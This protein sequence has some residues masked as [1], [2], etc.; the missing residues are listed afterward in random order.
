MSWPF[1]GGGFGKGFG[2][3]EM[4]VVLRLGWFSTGRDEAARQLLQVVT[5][6]IAS[7]FLGAEI[8]YVFCNRTRG[9]SPETD[10]FMDLV[11]KL[12]LPL[13]SLSSKGFL[14]SL[15]E[16]DREA[17][18]VRYHEEVAQRI[19]NLPV[20]LI[21]LA[22]YMLIVSGPFCQGF[23]LINLHPAEPG[24]PKG[25]WQEV[26]WEWIRRRASHGGV[27]IHRVTP[28]LDEGPPITYVT[29]SL[30]RG[31]LEGLWKD[32]ETKVK[33]RRWEEVIREEGEQTPLFQ[34]IRREGVRRELP[35]IVLTIQALSEG[36]V[37][38]AQGK[39]LDSEG[40]EI[41]GLCLNEEVEKWLRREES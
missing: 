23:S 29:F 41:G 22:G 28:D 38:V 7:G 8:V 15:R 34:A 36:R 13:I 6:H 3:G 16:R 9:E 11:E 21:V 40:K 24:G 2:Q 25:T 20:D 30:R 26:I 10:R 39:V 5:D 19:R 32:L 31:G 33:G 14:P 12:G 18:R 35:L 4:R 17:W 37:R 27:M 1:I